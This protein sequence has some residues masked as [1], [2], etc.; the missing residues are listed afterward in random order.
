MI[1]PD[2]YEYGLL[3]AAAVS[4]RST[5]LRRRYGAVIVN[6]DK[7]IVST[8]YNGAAR[9]IENCCD[10]GFCIRESMN[11][12][13]GERYEI[14]KAVHAEMN[15]VINGIP[16]E[17]K[18]GILFIYGEDKDRKVVDAAPCLL[19]QRV[20]AN[21]R[22]KEVVYTTPTGHISYLVNPKDTNYYKV[23]L[24]FGEHVR[25][26]YVSA[27]N[28]NIARDTVYVQ[29]SKVPNRLKKFA[30]SIGE[31]TSELYIEKPVSISK[32]DYES[33]RDA[34]VLPETDI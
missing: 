18:G 16:S 11:L 12:K 34:F 32:E 3:I 15:A 1:R 26:V 5:C 23:P 8:G 33:A 30:E 29:V 6:D 21:A 31:E 7:K 20:I 13:H 2:W 24:K 27:K 14:G 9:G 4:K 17:M 19:C 25:Y 28:E 10:T 22:I